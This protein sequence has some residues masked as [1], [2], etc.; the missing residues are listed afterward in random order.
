MPMVGHGVNMPKHKQ[1]LQIF[2]AVMQEDGVSIENFAQL[3]A[4]GCISASGSYR[5]IV[6][7]PDDVW[8]DIVEMQNENE[9]LL[10]PDYLSTP[11]PTPSIDPELDTPISKALR[12]RFNL[13][14]SSYA[15]MLLREI[16]RKSSAFSSQYKLS[17][18]KKS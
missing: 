14:T 13:K 15:T 6:A 18:A 5:K 11:D 4:N 12:M 8:F 7:R 9:D 10:T 17:L 16:T 1:L 2:E 3:A